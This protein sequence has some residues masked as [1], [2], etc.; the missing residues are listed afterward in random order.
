MAQQTDAGLV[1]SPLHCQ[2][3]PKKELYGSS[4]EACKHYCLWALLLDWVHRTHRPSLYKTPR[5]EKLRYLKRVA[6]KVCCSSWPARAF[7]CVFSRSW[8]DGWTG[9]FR[10]KS[11][12][13]KEVFAATQAPGDDGVGCSSTHIAYLWFWCFF[14]IISHCHI[15]ITTPMYF[16]PFWAFIWLQ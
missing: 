15:F 6:G 3:R 13:G 2:E 5:T 16:F 9:S 1:K 12:H 11:L 4:P 8:D 7:H 10:E 14:Y